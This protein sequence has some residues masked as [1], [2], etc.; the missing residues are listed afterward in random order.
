MG[1]SYS[2]SQSV[3]GMVI[4]AQGPAPQPTDMQTHVQRAQEVAV[5]LIGIRDSLTGL[6]GRLYGEG[7]TASEGKTGPRAAGLSSEMTG[8]LS[9]IEGISDQI[10][11]AA[12]RLSSFA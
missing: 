8:A 6:I 7:Q 5:R 11:Q 1:M 9:D 12:S 3:Q 10:F 2:T 4:A